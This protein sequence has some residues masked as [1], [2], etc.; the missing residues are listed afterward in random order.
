MSSESEGVEPAVDA[1]P[2][3]LTQNHDFLGY[4]FA[5]L[6]MLGGVMGFAKKRSRASL[7]AGLISG[8][9]VGFAA[10]RVS[11]DPSNAFF[12]TG[13]CG[14]LAGVMGYRFMKTKSFMPAGL[15]GSLSLVMT[16][17]YLYMQTQAKK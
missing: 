2:T 16:G 14:T 9:A 3:E 6:I 13:I 1:S 15:V 17:R 4:G 11:K 8:A 10:N 5:G 12:G 7:E